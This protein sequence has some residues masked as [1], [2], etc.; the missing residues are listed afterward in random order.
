MTD[1]D[2]CFQ[3]KKLPVIAT[4]F[5][6][7][8]LGDERSL[9]EFVV[10]DHICNKLIRQGENAV[11]YLVNDSYDPLNERQ[12]RVGVN[13]DEKLIRKFSEF[14]GRPIAEVPDP[15]DCHPSYAEHFADALLGRLR[16]LDIHPVLIDSYRSYKSGYYAPYIAS[17]LEN[18]SAIQRTLS[19]AF[20]SY[21]IQN[22]FHVQCPRCRCLDQTY[23]RTV[24]AQEVRFRCFRCNTDFREIRENIR[25][26]LGW[27]LDCAARW[28][29]YSIDL[30]TFSKSHLSPLGSFEISRFISQHFYAGQVPTP[31]KYGHLRIDKEM[32]YKLMEILPPKIFKMLLTT[33]M[34][35]D[36]EITKESVE[37]FCRNAFVRP[38]LSYVQYV[39]KNLPMRALGD[40]NELDDASGAKPVPAVSAQEK[41]LVDF[42]NRFSSFYYGKE[43]N[44]RLP[45]HVTV[46]SCDRET[47]RV[48]REIISYSVS[49]RSEVDGDP[50]SV[51]QRILSFIREH[52]EANRKVHEY[53]RKVVGVMEGPRISSL[54]KLLPIPQL[55]A[56]EMILRYYSGEHLAADSSDKGSK[57]P[58]EQCRLSGNVIDM[59]AP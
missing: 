53:L 38:G 23:I 20:D 9:R 54:L 41:E 36:I 3:Q 52:P 32:S 33:R 35:R 57:E 31:I 48:A 5:T 39:R 44:L 46:A 42:G 8:Y 18:Y 26:K 29:I 43:Y 51:N 59:I 25:G 55:R 50:S 27:K 12:L 10:G 37:N 14:C 2:K 6:S 1:H 4:G 49:V 58:Q 21:T 11:L 47:A 24:A 34:T 56:V 30:E 16:S 13:K 28:N 7:A 45:D 22:L 40:S 19:E 17:T 15:Y